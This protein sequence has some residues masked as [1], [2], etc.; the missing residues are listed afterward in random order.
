MVFVSGNHTN[1][2]EA[3][4]LEPSIAQKILAVHIMG[5]AVHAP[6]NIQSDWPAIDN[7][8]AEWNIWVDP[9]AAQEVFTAGLQLHLTPLDAT[10]QVV[11]TQSDLPAWT[12]SGSPEGAIAGDLLEWMLRSWSPDGVYIWDLVAAVNSTDPAFCPESPFSIDINVTPGP[13]QGAMLITDQPPNVSV[14]LDPDTSNV[15]A[16]V[17]GIFGK[18]VQ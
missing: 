8:V 3:L 13:E 12:A 6:G 16:R 18:G 9:R 7:R 5:G 2:A 11:W 15:K 14:C 1:L 4:R 10:K 17:S